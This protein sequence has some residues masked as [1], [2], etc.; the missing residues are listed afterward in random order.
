MQGKQQAP[1]PDFRPPTLSL[2]IAVFWGFISYRLY[3]GGQRGFEWMS[4]CSFITSIIATSQ[5]I[6]ALND[7]AKLHS[8]RKKHR[9]FRQ[10]GSKLGRAEL[11]SSQDVVNCDIFSDREGIFL[12]TLKP[13]PSARK[14]RDV[15]YNGDASIAVIAPPGEM[16][17][18]AIVVPTLISNPGQ[19]LI[20]NDVSGELLAICKPAL[21]AL[22]YEVKVVTPYPM[23][24][25]EMIGVD[26]SDCGIDIFSSFTPDMPPD[27]IRG[28]LATC[29][30]WLMPGKAASQQKDEYFLRSGRMIGA[31][32]AMQEMLEGRK[33]SLP[34]I[35][36]HL[37]KGM[38]SVHELC[39]QAEHSEAFGGV[40]AEQARSISTLLEKAPQQLAGGWGIAEQYLDP[41]DA[42][43]ALGKHTM[44][45]GLDP[46]S[47][48]SDRKQAVF[49]IH[50]LEKMETNAEVI[51]MTLTYLFDTL[52]K[53]SGPGKVTAMIDEAGSLNMPSLASSLNFYRKAS[54][55]CL[56]V[57]QDIAGQTEKTYG[58]AT[59]KQI[60]AACRL[61]IGMGLQEIETLR[62]FSDLCGTQAVATMSM[63]HPTERKKGSTERSESY[64]Y[65]SVPL[66]RP[67]E[68][69]TMKEILVIGGSLH[70]LMLTKVPYWT[71]KEWFRRAG[72]SPYYQGS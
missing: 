15:Y 28:D 35:R 57:F 7:Q 24:V 63:N 44:K 72:R 12:G 29:M 3:L 43:S 8:L 52:T 17:T 56:L 47:L 31:F 60:L 33:P 13:N 61:K 23:Q 27:R 10:A 55:R 65:Q 18:T 45:S 14:G 62:M 69:R 40:Y 59:A 19:N 25:A 37:M 49:L 11:A 71:R 42:S 68:I 67:E 54:L 6:R 2:A 36:R 4:L 46:R 51:A 48:K 58:K 22:G 70:P 64:S 30:Q 39:E 1:E 32:F 53:Q 21:E 41:F 34:G 50:T 66:L 9:T 5:V 20:I 38:A 16:K 26:V